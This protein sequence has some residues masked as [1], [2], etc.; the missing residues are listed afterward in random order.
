[1][2]DSTIRIIFEQQT[3]FGMYR[4][5]L[6]LPLDH[7]YSEEEIEAMKQKRIDNWIAMISNPPQESEITD[8]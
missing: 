4:D 6:Y 1:M 7:S 2:S 5:A 8:G 3:E